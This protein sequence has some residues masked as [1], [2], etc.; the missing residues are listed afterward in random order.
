MGLKVTQYQVNELV[1]RAVFFQSEILNP[2]SQIEGL[3][4]GKEWEKE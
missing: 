3:G 4:T 1:D 2:Q